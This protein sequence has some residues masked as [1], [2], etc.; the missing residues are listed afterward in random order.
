LVSCGGSM[1]CGK[2]LSFPLVRCVM[3]S[4][5]FCVVPEGPVTCSSLISIAPKP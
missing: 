5:C 3:N 4:F 2:G 1:L